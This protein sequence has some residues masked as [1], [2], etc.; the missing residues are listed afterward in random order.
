VPVL[1]IETAAF[2]SAARE[3]AN[4]L[5]GGAAWS[6]DL[7]D[8]L[9]FNPQYWF[10]IYLSIY[11]DLFGGVYERTKDMVKRAF[12]QKRQALIYFLQIGF[13]ITSFGI[14]IYFYQIMFPEIEKGN[15]VNPLQVVA[16]LSCLLFNF[17]YPFKPVRVRHLLILCFFLSLTSSLYLQ[18]IKWEIISLLFFVFL[19]FIF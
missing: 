11:I 13:L 15:L 3:G 14:F 6:L 12:T 2:E 10:F 16:Q 4:A 17:R 8:F 1:A 5:A 9:F 7:P 19:I 18:G